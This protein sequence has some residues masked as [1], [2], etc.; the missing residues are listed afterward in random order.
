MHVTPNISVIVVRT[1]DFEFQRKHSRH[2]RSRTVDVSPS[3]ESDNATIKQAYTHTGRHTGILL[4]TSKYAY[5]M[6]ICISTYRYTQHGDV[7]CALFKCT[8]IRNLY[9]R[10][11]RYK[12]T[13]F[14]IQLSRH[15]PRKT[16][17]NSTSRDSI[18]IA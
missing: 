12:K 6:Y 9:A 11:I 1:R 2:F 3:R 8:Y 14:L 18:D 15:G 7:K 16:N 10:F 4:I 17:I 13:R 5:T